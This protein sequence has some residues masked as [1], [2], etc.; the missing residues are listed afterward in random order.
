MKMYE[1]Q[2]QMTHETTFRLFTIMCV[3]WFEWFQMSFMTC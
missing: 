2:K 1:S 3:K